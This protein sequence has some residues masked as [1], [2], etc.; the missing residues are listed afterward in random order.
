[1]QPIA[2]MDES[3]EARLDGKPYPFV[4]LERAVVPQ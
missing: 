4:R 2:K 1:V 3:Y